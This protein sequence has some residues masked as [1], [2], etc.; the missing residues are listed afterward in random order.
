[1][2]SLLL[3]CPLCY[4]SVLSAT[5]DLRVRKDKVLL[6]TFSGFVQ[7][8]ISFWSSS[9]KIKDMFANYGTISGQFSENLLV[10]IMYLQVLWSAQ[11]VVLCAQ[12][13]REKR[14]R[15]RKREREER[16]REKRER[17]RERDSRN[18][19]VSAFP[20]SSRN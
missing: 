8:V 18:T 3:Q 11:A 6:P 10:R 16:E 9:F 1:M 15:E 2:S 12:E 4:F 17:K 19:C 20:L 7:I 13:R 5:S 14:E